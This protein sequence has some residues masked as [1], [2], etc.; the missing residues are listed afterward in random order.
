MAG[1]SRTL[2]VVIVGNADNAENAFRDLGNEARSLQ[3]EIDE[4]FQNSGQAADEVGGSV[5]GVGGKFGKLKGAVAGM[6][7]ALL[8]ALP[9][10]AVAA[11]GKGLD[12]I[13][14]RAQTAASMGL[15]GKDAATA[16]KLAGDL[17]VNGFGESTAETGQIVKRVHD[18][19]NMSVN[20]VDFKPIANKVATVSKVMGQDVGGTTRA[21]A[22]LMRN[23]LAKNANEAL[24]IV[25]SGFTHGVDKSEDF[26]DTLNEYGTQF[27][28]LGLNGA[29]A[30]GI[31]SQGLKGG[32]RDADLVADALK[33][34]SIRAVDGSATTAQG[35][36]A[37]GLNAS[38]MS[39]RI[40]KGGKSASD[41]LQLTMDK[42]RGIK[43]PVKQ[44]QAAVALFGTQS[45][46]LGKAL[47]SIDPKKAVDSLGKVKGSAQQM[48]D[49]MGKNAAAKLDSFKR[50][51]EYGLASGA[52]KAITAF[53]GLGKK[54]GPIFDGLKKSFTSGGFGKAID[55]IGQKLGEIWAVVQPSLMQFVSFFR[56]TLVPLFQELWQKAQ[57]MLQQLVAT[58]KTALD[59][60]K[61]EI[62]TF[63]TVVKFLW[64][65]FGA[66]IVSYVKSAFSALMSI[67]S[68]VL[69]V[70]QGIY[71]VFIGIFTGNWGKAWQGIKQIFS[72]VWQIIVGVFRAVMAT[73]RGILSAGMAAVRAVWHAVWGGIS[74][75]F[76]GLWSGITSWFSAK[77][78]AMRGFASSGVSAIK[79]FFVN[80]FHAL[81]DGVK[82]KLSSLVSAVKEIPGKAKAAL[83]G[84]KDS[85]LGIGRNII[86]G[87]V[88]GIRNSLGRV[89]SAAHAIVDKIPGPI[90]KALGIHSPSR[91][92][93]EIGK[94]IT[95]GLVKGMLGGTKSVER[96]AKKL[97][98]LV[99]KAFKAGKISKGK[100][101]DLH[102]YLHKQDVKL[103][104][105]AKD[106]EK[107]AAALKKAQDK[108]DGLKKAKSDMASSVAGKAR[109]YA[110][111]MGAYDSSEF[112]DN[113]ASAMLARLKKKLHGIMHFKKNLQTLAKRGFGKG[114]IN[115]LAQAGPEEGGKMAEALMNANAG[116]IKEF[117]S[118]YNAIND[119]SKKLG[120]FVSGNYYDAGIHSAEGIVKGLK[121]KESAITKAITNLAKKMVK[122]LKKALGIKSPSRVFMGLGGFTAQ[123]FAHGI[124]KGQGDV[125]TA[126]DQLAGTRPSGRLASRS[127][128]RATAWHAAHAGPTPP[129]VYVT[130]QGHVTAEKNL[131]KAIASTVR[132]EIVRGGKRNGGRT[133]L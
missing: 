106:R 64:Q 2:R 94:F 24:D 8:A 80:G 72:G 5:E 129:N 33:E 78:S 89:M 61:V 54:V 34:F 92:M 59:W 63:V 65:T 1:D 58:V 25:A 127:I 130:V 13:G 10:A 100:A 30:T 29:T 40:G 36:K 23:G 83:S 103:W 97:H 38:D 74:S 9:L 115:Q 48:S 60:V 119:Q 6:G 86:D 88:N 90:R 126:I 125:Q 122:A 114:I 18:D 26:L 93:A 12:E 84:L 105:L 71:N 16:G 111:F 3:D 73:V 42:L 45:E 4:S 81:Y 44:S 7:A 66:T 76:R 79:N 57:P 20:S 50:K 15:T 17:Y 113:S 109:D 91:V 77:L 11:L 70:I 69:T 98:E 118:T 107:V 46:D 62:Q 82:G 32:A 99:T 108:L 31:L 51:L 68:G 102:A 52:A 95:Q 21:V 39:K 116:Q 87:I 131:A 96:T 123:G 101:N 22:N 55:G 120:K 112:A 49:T 37:I 67:I 35:F 85:M 27:R 133:G 124:R 75:F 14:N 121:K 19:L 28:K 53:E 47:Y 117:N 43:D 110:S 104:H 128:A 132:D 56:T 41:A